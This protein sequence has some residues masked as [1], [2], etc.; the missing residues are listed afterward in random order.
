MP[1]NGCDSQGGAIEALGLFSSHLRLLRNSVP[2]IVASA[3]LLLTPS[4]VVLSV[5]D[6]RY[7]ELVS[8]PVEG[9]F[10]SLLVH[11]ILTNFS[12]AIFLFAGIVTLGLGALVGSL[13]LGMFLTFS[14]STA[15]GTFGLSYIVAQT[16]FYTPLEIYG[17]V[18][19]GASGLVVTRYIF[20]ERKSPLQ[21][22][23]CARSRSCTLL[24]HALLFLG[25]SAALE[26]IGAL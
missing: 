17:F 12:S 13:V 1:V 16:W 2:E 21:A 18:L 8:D 11:I 24:C 5:T 14:I 25:V 19:A 4:I 9:T 23:N 6:L 15:I 26:A 10:W 22:F 3:V 7:F 20:I